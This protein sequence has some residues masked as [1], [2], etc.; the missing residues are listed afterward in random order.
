[1]T[2]PKRCTYGVRYVQG[3]TFTSRRYDYSEQCT[4]DATGRSTIGQPRCDEHRAYRYLV[5]VGLSLFLTK[6]VHDDDRGA[7]AEALSRLGSH[8]HHIS[9]SN[10]TARPATATDIER[11]EA[12]AAQTLESVTVA[13][14]PR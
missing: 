9:P 14:S 13:G 12:I 2:A 11:F 6:Q 8:G 4:N 3:E 1:M 5:T 7:K 10:M